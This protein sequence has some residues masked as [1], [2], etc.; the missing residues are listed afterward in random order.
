ML[1]L[2]DWLETA[3]ALRLGAAIR[4][5]HG[6]ES[7]KNLEITNTATEWRCWCFSCNTG[8][9]VRKDYVKMESVV[10]RVG[11][12]VVIPNDIKP[13]NPTDSTGLMIQ[14]FLA[15]RNMSPVFLP[16]IHVSDSTCR[17]FIKDQYGLWHGR[18]L[19]GRS[20]QKWMHEAYPSEPVVNTTTVLVEDLLSHYKLKWVFRK[21]ND[22]SIVC[23]FGT[24]ISERLRAHIVA[25]GVRRLVFALDGDRA[26]DA[27]YTKGHRDMN[28]WGIECLRARPPEGKDPKDMFIED[29]EKLLENAK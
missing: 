19:T 18:D 7:R 26:G 13:W 21:N 15:A 20:G 25:R 23:L 10:E 2:E 27:G 17:F 16:E 11:N 29:L 4:I 1:P 8:G 9:I 3:K 24:R 14:K 28:V 12:K 5:Q 6:S 22:V